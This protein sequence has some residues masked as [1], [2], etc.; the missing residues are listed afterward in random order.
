MK[1][2]SDKNPY[3]GCLYDNEASIDS[4]DVYHAR[5]LEG[6]NR[7]SIS[8]RVVTSECIDFSFSP[9]C[10][11]VLFHRLPSETLTV[12]WKVFVNNK[13]LIVLFVFTVGG[14]NGVLE[15]DLNNS[16]L[17]IM[18]V[19]R[20]AK[21]C[22]FQED[23]HHRPSDVNKQVKPIPLPADPC[24]LLRPYCHQVHNSPTN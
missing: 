2:K 16:A 15:G 18:D 22:K 4:K 8:Q 1:W 11:F 24:P 13:R 7:W 23:H 21:K 19:Q 3:I 20:N 5:Q 17:N 6:K 12:G 9:H 10:P 14:W